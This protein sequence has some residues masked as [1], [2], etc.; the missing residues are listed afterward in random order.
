MALIRSKIELA[1]G[2]RGI[3]AKSVKLI[4]VTKNANLDRIEEAI[5][6]GLAD[7]G[8]NRV[9]EAVIKHKSIGNKA[10]WHLIGHLQTNKVKDA[11]KIFSLIQSVDSIRLAREIDSRAREASKIQDIL[12]EVNISGEDRKFGVAPDAAP[13]FV[14]EVSLYPNIHIAGLMGMAPLVENQ[15][16]ARVYFKRLKNIFDV[17]SSMDIANAE[18]KWLSMGMSQDFEVAI[19]EGSNMVR[20][21]SAI[22]KE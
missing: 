17:L 19:E 12:V 8:E 14:K 1:A 11:V 15:E 13:N 5:G 16:D 4:C 3:D 21:G 2:R 20:I 9:Q 22:F 10:I 18:M 6:L 7:M